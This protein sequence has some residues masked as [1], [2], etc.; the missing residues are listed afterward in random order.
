VRSQAGKP[1]SLRDQPRAA[2]DDVR[3]RSLQ[4]R[5]T[6]SSRVSRAVSSCPGSLPS[7]STTTVQHPIVSIF[8]HQLSVGAAP[9]AHQVSTWKTMFARRCPPQ[10]QQGRCLGSRLPSR[11]SSSAGMMR[12]APQRFSRRISALGDVEAV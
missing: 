9:D 10:L 5:S 12:G 11:S 2:L 7:V 1:D 6:W 3:S 4:L 8:T